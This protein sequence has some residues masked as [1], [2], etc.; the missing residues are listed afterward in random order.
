[1]KVVDIIMKFVLCSILAV[2]GICFQCNALAKDMIIEEDVNVPSPI[3]N[4]NGNLKVGNS[5]NGKIRIQGGAIVF[6]TGGYLGYYPEAQGTAI[7][8]GAGSSWINNKNLHVGF[9]GNGELDIQDGATV[10][11]TDGYLGYYREAQGTAIISGTGSKWIN[12]KN[13]HVGFSGN[14]ALDIQGGA[15]VFNI[16][17]HVGSH[18]D[19][20]GTA[21]VSGTGSK[22]INSGNLFVGDNGSG[23]LTIKDGGFLFNA[24]AYL[25]YEKESSGIVLVA[26]SRSAWNTTRNLHVGLRGDGELRI[27]DGA[28]VFN[29]DGYLG[30]YREA[31]GT[32][33]VSGT[34]SKWINN[35]NLHVGFSGNGELDIQDGATVSSERIFVAKESTSTGSIIIGAIASDSAKTPGNID[36]STIV[37]G[38][39]QGSILLN[40]TGTDYSLSSD[41]ISEGIG[42]HEI[43]HLAGTT[44]LTGSIS[45][46]TGSLNIDGG[47]LT[48][49]GPDLPGGNIDISKDASLTIEQ[50]SMAS[51]SGVLSNSGTFNITGVGAV[52]LTG[53]SSIFSGVTNV[54]NGKLIVGSADGG[55]L[56]GTV[57]IGSNGL[58]TGTGMV[59]SLSK[60]TIITAGGVHIPGDFSGGSQHIA[61]DYIN[62]GILRIDASPSGAGKVIVAGDVDI[63]G[64][65]LDIISTTKKHSSSSPDWD[66]LSGPFTII[67]K[68][69]SGDVTGTFGSISNNLLF[70]DSFISY[71]GGDGNDVTLTLV[72]NDRSFTGVACTRNQKAAASSIEAIG[73]GHSIW[74]KIILI[75][76]E[77]D[78]CNA[79]D[80]LSGEIYASE[81]SSLITDEQFLRDTV[82]N[83]LLSSF[84]NHEV[85]S[86]M[87]T[88]CDF[89]DSFTIY[90]ENFNF[91][92]HGFSSSGHTD[93]SDNAARLNHS[94]GGFFAGI[95]SWVSDTLQTGILIGYSHSSFSVWNHKSTGLSNNYPIAFYSGAHWGA[96]SLRGGSAYTWHNISTDRNVVFPGF[97]ETLKNDHR[98]RTVQF[99]EEF[100]YN[101]MVDSC[102]FKPFANLAYVNLHTGSFTERDGTSA[103]SGKSDHTNVTFTTL[104]LRA[105]KNFSLT[106]DSVATARSMIGWQRAFGNIVPTNIHAFHESEMF[107]VTGVPIARNS[108]TIESA[109]DWNCSQTT[110]I[111]FSYIGRLSSKAQDHGVKTSL[112]IRL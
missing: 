70:L 77:E 76:E 74:D 17:G 13:L 31:Q 51:Y 105:S 8:S 18:T 28:I 26:G 12:N 24:H 58:L 97:S 91:W 2:F 22:W 33:I 100:G 82:N 96:F 46:F 35:K 83:R 4:I 16:D 106:K 30:S 49:A 78:A 15:T 45:G 110:T 69:S 29:I 79:F 3:W 68:Q 9:S 90:N 10:F 72:R 1:M 50:S 56:G 112:N 80:A 44:R 84:K 37:F 104:G 63:S 98:S 111:S 60:K 73:H 48:I 61:G 11:N 59:S 27:Q 42:N 21:I 32:A 109:I 55:E 95:D 39:G 6:N 67:D 66:P 103:L 92:T 102:N 23:N 7:I 85:S 34:G 81:K 5:K 65:S 94:I 108:I 101:M 93:N 64:A 89:D 107:A 43:R 54:T 88:A 57:I 38:D 14:G 71:D 52:T 41:F 75:H 19:A 62:H 53:D 86:M 40:H 87:T 25:G 20:Q 47:S 99:F 36:T